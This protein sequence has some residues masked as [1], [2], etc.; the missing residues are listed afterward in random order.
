MVT[1][2]RAVSRVRVMVDALRDGTPSIVHAWG[3][4][5]VLLLY[6]H[7]LALLQAVRDIREPSGEALSKYELRADLVIVLDEL[8]KLSA[9]AG[10]EVEE[11]MVTSAVV[12][13]WDSSRTPP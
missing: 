12:G 13:E 5:G 9:F 4:D 2:A 10:I 7:I 3:S 8:S 11:Y 6:I 1:Q